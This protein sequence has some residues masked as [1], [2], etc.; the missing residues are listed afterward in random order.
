M[1]AV[2]HEGLSMCLQQTSLALCSPM[3]VLG[4]G[5]FLF[6]VCAGAHFPGL[7]QAGLGRGVD[8]TPQQQGVWP[9]RIGRGSVGE[10]DAG[11]WGSWGLWRL[12][13]LRSTWAMAS[14][15][16]P[17]PVGAALKALWHLGGAAR[18]KDIDQSSSAGSNAGIVRGFRPLL[19]A[20]PDSAPRRG[21]LPVVSILSWSL[22]IH[23]SL[24]QDLTSKLP[25]LPACLA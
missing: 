13:S 17:H 15:P 9:S 21:L 6:L 22:S 25:S 5:A 8:G 11:Q 19:Y 2:P 12:H 14:Q 24:G 4:L 7:P 10:T 1:E 18:S 20:V 23:L 16:Y 3:Q